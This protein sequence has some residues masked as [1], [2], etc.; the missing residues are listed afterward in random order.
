MPHQIISETLPYDLYR[1]VR[2]TNRESSSEPLR[3]SCIVGHVE[4]KDLPYVNYREVLM[5]T[6]TP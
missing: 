1:V 6:E 4:I 5:H 3:L 2:P